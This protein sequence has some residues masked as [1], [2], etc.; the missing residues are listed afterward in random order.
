MKGHYIN[1]AAA[2]FGAFAAGVS[3]AR[4]DMLFLAINLVLFSVN[5]W[6]FVAR[7]RPSATEG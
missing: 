5:A 4:D 2:L 7:S 1:G 3:F 6:V